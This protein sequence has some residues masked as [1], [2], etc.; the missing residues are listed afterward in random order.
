MIGG[1]RR[2]LLGAVVLAQGLVAI[3][4]LADTETCARAYEQ[5]QVARQEAKLVEARRELVTCAQDQCPAVLRK[6][7][8][9]WL[10]EIEASIPRLS[11]HVR[12]ADGCDRPD[13]RVWLDDGL[14]PGAANGLPI[15]VNPG[16]HAVK[17]EADG[18]TAARSIVLAIGERR[19]VVSIDFAP[20]NA[21]CGAPLAATG[22][23]SLGPAPSGERT[24][25]PTLAYVLAGVGA[26]SALLASGFGISAWSQKAELDDCKGACARRD[27][28]TMERTFLVADI[29]AGLAVASLAAAAAVYFFAR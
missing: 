11:I 21:R 23:A 16:T 3:P 8:A 13:A 12:G 27:V 7:C 20:E 18:K 9:G 1:V 28:D 24:S 6:D 26:T 17:V 19:K 25:R 5:A 22:R 4:A 29:G 15:D 2:S 14:A 10:T